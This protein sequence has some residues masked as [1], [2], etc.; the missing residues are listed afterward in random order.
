MLNYC[1]LFSPTANKMWL[2]SLS[3]IWVQQA[4]MRNV[5]NL[6]TI[7]END[8]GVKYVPSSKELTKTRI[9]TLQADYQP[10][11]VDVFLP[12][13]SVLQ[14]AEFTTMLYI[15]ATPLISV[16]WS[17]VGNAPVFPPYPNPLFLPTLTSFSKN[18]QIF[19]MLILLSHKLEAE[20]KRTYQFLG[21]SIKLHTRPISLTILWEEQKWVTIQKNY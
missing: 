3:H 16:L 13:K 18:F 21:W 20:H 5:R 2:R 14:W 11:A 19:R 17:Y 10:M 8:S 12:T 15:P 7:Y 1:D 4:W 6:T 9:S